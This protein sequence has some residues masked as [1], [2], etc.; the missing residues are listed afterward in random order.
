MGYIAK[1]RGRYRVR[2]R[3]PRCRV[4]PKS[5]VRKSEAEGR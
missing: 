3:D 5:F 4:H 2:I 1:E